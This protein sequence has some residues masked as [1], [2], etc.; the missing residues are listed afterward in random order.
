MSAAA[1]LVQSGGR[2]ATWITG[3]WLGFAGS[4]LVLSHPPV[5]SHV[6]KKY[7]DNDTQKFIKGYSI[8]AGAFFFP[9]VVIYGAKR[10]AGP[11]LHSMGNSR[12]MSL[13]GTSIRGLALVTASQIAANPPAA[14][15]VVAT[16]AEM[17]DKIKGLT[18]ITRHGVFTALSLWGIANVLTRGSL[19]ALAFWAPFPLF[20][21]VGALHQDYRHKEDGTKPASYFD[22]TSVIPFQAIREGKQDLQKAL[23][24]L[25]YQYMGIALG[26]GALVTFASSLFAKSA[27]VALSIT[28][29]KPSRSN[30]TH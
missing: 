22:K 27:V 12:F 19:V 13:V 15:P 3:L 4:H 29:P 30:P 20:S 23:S 6:I 11:Q 1:P 21:Y 26:A 10:N 9:M 24:E 16:E 25:N 14:S 7:C 8:L 18:R 5:R 2:A 17:D 28:T